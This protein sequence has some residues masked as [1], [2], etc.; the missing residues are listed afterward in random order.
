MGWA[1]EDRTEE[2]AGPGEGFRDMSQKLWS[3]VVD[4]G[5]THA[6]TFSLTFY[7]AGSGPSFRCARQVLY[8]TLTLGAMEAV[9]LL[10]RNRRHMHMHTQLS[11]IQNRSPVTE[12]RGLT[13]ATQVASR[14]GS[15]LYS[16]ILFL[17]CWAPASHSPHYISVCSYEILP[18]Q[19]SAGY[20]VGTLTSLIQPSWDLGRTC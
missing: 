17:A 19:H 7:H 4:F 18:S 15:T 5:H 11:W 20:T 9:L 16:T 3:R 14:Q 2:A 1:C 10:C 12:E 8:Q 13:K 6:H